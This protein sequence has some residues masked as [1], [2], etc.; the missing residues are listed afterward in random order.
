[1]K[2]Q[3]LIILLLASFLSSCGSQVCI[4]ADDFGFAQVVISARYPNPVDKLNTTGT[5]EHFSYLNSYNNQDVGAWLDSGYALNGQPLTIMVRNWQYDKFRNN[6]TPGF[7]SA[8]SPWFGK[9]INYN[10]LPNYLLNLRS[11]SFYNND[12]C[13]ADQP[14][15]VRIQNA[16]CLMKKGMGLYGLITLPN[17]STPA[18]PNLDVSTMYDPVSMLSKDLDY[19]PMVFHVGDVHNNANLFD[20]NNSYQPGFENNTAQSS[21]AG[22]IV[23][24]CG[25]GN[26]ASGSGASGNCD[27]SSPSCNSYIQNDMNSYAGGNLFFKILDI[28]YSDNAGQ[29]IAVIKSGVKNI[30][31]NPFADLADECRAMIFGGNGAITKIAYPGVVPTIYK[32]I[33]AQ[34]DYLLTIQAM[35]ILYMIFTA[36]GFLIGVVKFTQIELFLRTIKVIIISILINTSY[37]W[38]F[39]NT[40]LFSSFINGL[41]FVVSLIEQ[42]ASGGQTQGGEDMIALIFSQQTMAKLSSL[43]LVS[44]SGWAYCLIFMVLA[45][46]IVIMYLKAYILYTTALLLLGVIICSAPIFLVFMLF[47]VTKHFYNNWL[48]KMIVY[49][50]Q[51]LILFASLAFLGNM[52]RHEIYSSLGF[53]VCQIPII[54][55][56]ITPSPLLSMYYPQPQSAAG[57]SASPLTCMAVPQGM[58][59]RDDEGNVTGY[60]PPYTYQQK[61]YIDMPFLDPNN[62][63]DAEKIHSLQQNGLSI[64]FSGLFYLILITLILSKFNDSTLDITGSIIGDPLAEAMSGASK[65]F[66]KNISFYGKQAK[67]AVGNKLQTYASVR[68]LNSSYNTIVLGAKYVGKKIDNFARAPMLSMVK[69]TTKLE[70]AAKS[71]RLAEQFGVTNSLKRSWQADQLKHELNINFNSLKKE[72]IGWKRQTASKW[73]Q[74]QSNFVYKMHASYD[75]T[76]TTFERLSI[77]PQKGFRQ[78]FERS[79]MAAPA[80]TKLQTAAPKKLV[81]SQNLQEKLFN[82]FSNTFSPRQLA[83]TCFVNRAICY[84]TTL[85]IFQKLIYDDEYT[86]LQKDF[87]KHHEHAKMTQEKETSDAKVTRWAQERSSIYATYQEEKLKPE[88]NTAEL[89]QQLRQNLDN[90]LDDLN[91][92]YSQDQERQAAEK[93]ERQQLQENKTQWFKERSEIYRQ[94]NEQKAQVTLLPKEERKAAMAELIEHKRKA[95][96][97]ISMR[98]LMKQ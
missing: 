8:W 55:I 49:A 41:D 37:S 47:G 91:I 2:L 97:T 24:G 75:A 94:F 4:D 95:L 12:S 70:F 78:L 26:G 3:Y 83:K 18:N 54:D 20:I 22:G 25:S 67:K 30:G 74:R 64:D 14:D 44:L 9:A 50:F 59:T 76:R 38:D 68:A 40:Y 98:H 86:L 52:V 42:A 17:Y 53:K 48:K 1:M 92:R 46:F 29:Y 45:G 62:P 6:A 58:T 28:D 60:Y 72:A 79:K 80:P 61:R 5:M 36:T 90:K 43:L 84:N 32:N 65:D 93:Q 85:S 15:N 27:A 39:F 89:Q 11:C 69:N 31:F 71:P 16:P 19:K 87:A 13:S 88:N 10:N 33:L 82:T 66:N 7:L 23:I 56:G 34:S 21:P 57:F 73:Q 77:N 81:N 96:E 63:Q 35:L 51:P